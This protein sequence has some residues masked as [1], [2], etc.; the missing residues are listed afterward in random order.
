MRKLGV[1][2]SKNELG[3]S[4]KFNWRNF[5]KIFN[6]QYSSPTDLTYTTNKL[7][8]QSPLR[9]T[10]TTTFE[11]DRNIALETSFVEVCPAIDNPVSYFQS[12]LPSLFW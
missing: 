1:E 12:I 8:D 6:I 9:L 11:T 4:E 2:I 7:E 5:K 10:S 3:L